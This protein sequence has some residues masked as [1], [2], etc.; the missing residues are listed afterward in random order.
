MSRTCR[1]S[2]TSTADRA[3][4]GPTPMI[5]TISIPRDP[6]SLSLLITLFF[7]FYFKG[8]RKKKKKVS[9]ALWHVNI[10]PLID[11]NYD[12]N[13][14]HSEA[15]PHRI[16]MN[17]YIWLFSTNVL[18]WVMRYTVLPRLLIE[19]S[20]TWVP[21]KFSDSAYMGRGNI[22]HPSSWYAAWFPFI[23]VSPPCSHCTF[24]S[25]LIY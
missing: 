6:Y 5:G 21:Q 10:S 1:S 19:G 23:T 12:E 18:C 22:T 14:V 8:R 16:V 7:I 11:C 17:I 25:P 4:I 3:S 13:G 2:G 9:C 15:R 24:P 20:V